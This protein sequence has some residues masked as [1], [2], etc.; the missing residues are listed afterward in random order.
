MDALRKALN[1]RS[2]LK[3]Y[4]KERKLSAS[5]L[6]LR[7]GFHRSFLSHLLNGKRR[8][9]AKNSYAIEKVLQV[10]AKAKL[11]FRLLVALEEA[12]LYPEIPRTSITMRLE[13]L[14]KKSWSNPRRQTAPVD[15]SDVENIFLN[16]NIMTIF[17]ACGEPQYPASLSTVIQ[18]SRIKPE[19]VARGLNDLIAAGLVKHDSEAQVFETTDIHLYLRL[20][21]KNLVFESLM[22]NAINETSRRLP[23]GIQSDE[24]FFF[25]SQ[26]CIRRDNMPA[27]K[28]GLRKLIIEFTDNAI[29]TNGDSII[30][31]FTA[32]HL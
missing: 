2:F 30:K 3:I 12:D 8:I 15:P 26:L 25:V 20:K 21:N 14:K 28:E 16:P 4:L 7:A 22:I 11:F 6:A 10:P 29:D 31:L 19:L 5:A 18:R 17:A 27:L 24:E 1:Y 13:D 32:F 9:T 23:T